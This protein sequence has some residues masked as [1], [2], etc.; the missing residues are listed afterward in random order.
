MC[1]V[2]FKTAYTLIIILC[3]ITWKTQILWNKVQVLKS[4]IILLPFPRNFLYT[5][6]RLHIHAQLLTLMFKIDVMKN[7][8]L[9]IHHVIMENPEEIIYKNAHKSLCKSP[10]KTFVSTEFSFSK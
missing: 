2:L 3:V 9:R 5:D 7:Q 1:W 10:P 8:R 4:R 6:F